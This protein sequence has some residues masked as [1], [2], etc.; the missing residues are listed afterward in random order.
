M[1]ACEGEISIFEP[2]HCLCAG[3]LPECAAAVALLL[4]APLAQAQDLSQD[5]LY[6]TVTLRAGFMPDPN[7]TPLTA[8]GGSEVTISGCT[9]TVAEAP[10]LNLN[11]TGRSS[12]LYIFATSGSDTTLPVNLPDG[13]WRCDDDSYGDGDPLVI[14][15]N[16]PSGLYNIWAGTYGGGTAAANVMISEID[17]R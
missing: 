11:W 15:R 17:P 16:A 6:G 4:A 10:D 5:P 14:I 7:T 13:D 8:G 1:L 3:R 9:G 12:T 2:L